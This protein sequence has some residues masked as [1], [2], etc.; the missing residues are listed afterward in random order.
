MRPDTYV[1]STKTSV[2]QMFVADQIND[3]KKSKLILS[4]IN[5]NSG[6][7]KLFDEI[8]TNASDQYI[9]T[10]Q[11]KNIKVNVFKDHI[12]IENDGPGIPVEIHKEHK[13]YIPEL[14][15]G[16]MLSSSNFDDNE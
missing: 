12:S 16:H 1:G 11:V 5:Y 9:R 14:I 7:F 15:F 10:E 6:F 13:I 2:K 3:I 8:L 4:R